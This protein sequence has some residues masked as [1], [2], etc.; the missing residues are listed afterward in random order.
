MPVGVAVGVGWWCGGD[1]PGC[2][3]LDAVVVSAEVDEVG[4]GGV[5]SVGPVGDVVDVAAG[6]SALAAG[7]AAGFV[8]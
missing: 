4:V 3:V 8:A 2:V 5:A 1:G 7:E 6:G